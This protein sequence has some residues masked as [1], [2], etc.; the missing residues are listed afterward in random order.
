MGWLWAMSE[1]EE[2]TSSTPTSLGQGPCDFLQS[3]GSAW[4]DLLAAPTKASK[5]RLVIV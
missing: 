2:R 4:P 1:S 5:Y 3:V